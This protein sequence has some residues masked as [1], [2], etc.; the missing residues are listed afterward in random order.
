MR[1]KKLVHNLKFQINLGHREGGRLGSLK[2]KSDFR[3]KEK[4][5][6]NVSKWCSLLDAAPLRNHAKI[7]ILCIF[8]VMSRGLIGAGTVCL[9]CM[10]TKKLISYSRG[11]RNFQYLL[12]NGVM[13]FL[14][15][16]RHPPYRCPWINAIVRLLL[17]GQFSYNY[18][19]P[20]WN[21]CIY[22]CES[23]MIFFQTRQGIMNQLINKSIMK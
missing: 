9:V 6:T 2:A 11:G 14:S 1:N 22:F 23:K 21:H 20:Y 7:H 4:Y 12:K 15:K 8:Y 17:F 5:R 16:P 13:K 10:V 3:C 19:Q 18:I